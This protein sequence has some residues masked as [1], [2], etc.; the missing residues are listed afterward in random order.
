MAAGGARRGD[1]DGAI[2]RPAGQTSASDSDD[3]GRG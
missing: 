3:G 2:W 1:G